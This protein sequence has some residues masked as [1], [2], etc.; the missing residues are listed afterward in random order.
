MSSLFSRSNQK[1]VSGKGALNALSEI[2]AS[3]NAKNAVVI[4]DAGVFK[5]GLTVKAEAL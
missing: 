2:V 4:T 5:A 3:L 1:I